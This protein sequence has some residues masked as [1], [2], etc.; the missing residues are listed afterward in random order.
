M[1]GGFVI[2]SFCVLR[3]G[4]AYTTSGKVSDEATLLSL[5][6]IEHIVP[7]KGLYLTDESQRLIR[8]RGSPE[9]NFGQ[10]YTRAVRLL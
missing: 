4:R 6:M 1:K 8:P 2:K 9:G 10:A 7:G 5:V 3:I